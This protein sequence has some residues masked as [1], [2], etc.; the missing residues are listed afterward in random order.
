MNATK[1]QLYEKFRNKLVK[2]F[3]KLRK[4]YK[5]GELEPQAPDNSKKMSSSM[6]TPGLQSSIKISFNNQN[7]EA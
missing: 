7:Q 6:A 3:P 5:K 1:S 4:K 2:Q